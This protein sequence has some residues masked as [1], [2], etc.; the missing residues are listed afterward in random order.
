MFRVYLHMQTLLLLLLAYPL[1]HV[2][3]RH[4]HHPGQAVCA[5]HPPS[6]SL[7]PLR[8]RRRNV[9]QQR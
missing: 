6:P 7:P 2:I 4:P 1:M 3:L 5:A 9:L 8:R